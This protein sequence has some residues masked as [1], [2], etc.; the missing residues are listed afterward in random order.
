MKKK[1]SKKLENIRNLTLVKNNNQEQLQASD[2]KIYFPENQY[3]VWKIRASLLRNKNPYKNSIV[4][5]ALETTK[6][7]IDHLNVFQII[8]TV[9]TMAQVSTNKTNN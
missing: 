9:T 5:V 3:S 4:K 2:K 6:V 8:P 1:F 7:L